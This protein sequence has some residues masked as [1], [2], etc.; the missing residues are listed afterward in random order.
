M[1][2]PREIAK[3]VNDPSMFADLEA[4][5]DAEAGCPTAVAGKAAERSYAVNPTNP[6]EPAAPAKNLKR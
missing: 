1:P 6:P 2:T 4:G 3:K 5:Y